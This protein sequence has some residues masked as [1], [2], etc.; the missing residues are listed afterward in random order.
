MFNLS[1]W[2]W[3]SDRNE[4]NRAIWANREIVEILENLRKS[5]KSI[6][7]TQSKSGV[8][9]R[10]RNRANRANREIVQI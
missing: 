2:V 10:D 6:E 1:L 5:G 3:D 4:G 9:S 7:H 8:W